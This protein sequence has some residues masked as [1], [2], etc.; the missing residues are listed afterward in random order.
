MDVDIRPV[1]PAE[2]R[3]LGE[4]TAQAYLREG[5]LGGDQDP[6]L[7]FLRDVSGRASS[8]LVL[9]AVDEDRLLGGVTYVPGPGPMADLA[10][11]GEA[12]IR[13]LAVDAEAR[14]RGVGEALAR[15]CLD[16]AK[17]AGVGRVVLSSQTAMRAA[18]RLYERLGFQ[19]LPERDWSPENKPG[20]VLVA[21]ALDLDPDLDPGTATR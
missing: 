12:E 21:Y 2:H 16:Q 1:T 13:M 4:L 17:A 20:L 5:F 10:R 14:G 3:P 18:H 8:A 19:R 7:P 6:Y 11:E 9:V 15:A